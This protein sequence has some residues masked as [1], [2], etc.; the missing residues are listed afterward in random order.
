MFPAQRQQRILQLLADRGALGSAELAEELDVSYETVRRDLNALELVQ[1][2]VR[3]HGG[4]QLTN[5]RGLEPSYRDRA[6][7]AVEAKAAIGRAAARLVEPG[8]SVMI[9]VGTTTLEVARALD[10]GFQG[11][12]I[13]SSILA[14]VELAERRDVEV[15]VNAGRV[16]GGDLSISGGLASDFYRDVFPDIAFVGS[17]GVDEHAGLTDFH[18]DEVV[19]RRVVLAN[20]ARAYV[21]A[22]ASKLGRVAAHRVCALNDFDGL[23]TNEEPPSGVDSAIKRGG[24]EVIVAA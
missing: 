21:L 19:A 2:V 6:G 13:T 4:V 11:T 17:G 16:R 22:D 8:M 15:I 5:A 24:G 18:L 20:A 3:R 1:K 7:I 23:I 12:V 10:A 9:D 14:A